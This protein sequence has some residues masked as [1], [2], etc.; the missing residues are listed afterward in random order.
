MEACVAAFLVRLRQSNSLFAILRRKGIA[1]HNLKQLSQKSDISSLN[2]SFI[3]HVSKRSTAAD[4][5]RSGTVQTAAQIC[6][7]VC[8][9]LT[10]L[11]GWRISQL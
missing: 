3:V 9:D 2:L 7:N 1:W 6:R 10:E 11:H 8:G 4:V 5:R